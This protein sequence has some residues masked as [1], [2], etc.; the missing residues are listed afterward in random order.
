MTFIWPST[1]S[2]IENV[3]LRI[4]NLLLNLL[5]LH[6]LK[7]F[8]ISNCCNTLRS[9]ITFSSIN[10]PCSFQILPRVDSSPYPRLLLKIATWTKCKPT[11]TK[12]Q[13]T[14]TLRRVPPA[15]KQANLLLK[16]NNTIHPLWLPRVALE[17][18]FFKPKVALD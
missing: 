8:S 1:W 2:Q 10:M 12:I 5:N 11:A 17:Q 9:T 15:T 7:T 18:S 4:S 6:F 13:L 14:S 16:E 3:Q